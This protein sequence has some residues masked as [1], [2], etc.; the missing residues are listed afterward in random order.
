MIRIRRRYLSV[1]RCQA[2]DPALLHAGAV[3]WG[4]RTGP[5]VPGACGADDTGRGS[6][7]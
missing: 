5:A 7:I 3:G 1:N 4:R 2:C 6:H